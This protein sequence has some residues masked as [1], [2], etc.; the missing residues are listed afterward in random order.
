MEEAV[1]IEQATQ[2]PH[3]RDSK[4]WSISTAVMITNISKRISME[5]PSDNVKPSACRLSDCE[6]NDGNII[7]QTRQIQVKYKTRK[8]CRRQHSFPSLPEFKSSL[9][10]LRCLQL[11]AAEDIRKTQRLQTS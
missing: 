7:Q 6:G 1:S 4:S 8:L 10:I 5:R 3:F 2:E 11:F 9:R